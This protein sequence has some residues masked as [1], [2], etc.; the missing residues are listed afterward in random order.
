MQPN[1]Q[2]RPWNAFSCSPGWTVLTHGF[3]DV[4]RGQGFGLP[5]RT[6]EADGKCTARIAGRCACSHRRSNFS[7]RSMR[8]DKS[9][10]P[11]SFAKRQLQIIE[12][13]GRRNDGADLA[14]KPLPF[15]CQKKPQNGSI[16]HIPV[17]LNSTYRKDSR[18][19]AEALNEY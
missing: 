12:P 3:R 7:A 13:V 18:D 16:S 4:R 14:L 11:V 2:Y 9:V 5:L 6:Y 10:A 15:C 1:S 8:L 17:H 19:R